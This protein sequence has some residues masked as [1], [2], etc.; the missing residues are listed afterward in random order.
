MKEGDQRFDTIST[1]SII[2]ESQG[3][4]SGSIVCVSTTSNKCNGK[5]GI[6]G[7]NA[8]TKILNRIY[9]VRGEKILLDRD[10][11]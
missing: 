5:E 8:G 4:T 11:G 9:V 7:I 2:L 6:T 3:M 10:F 1:E